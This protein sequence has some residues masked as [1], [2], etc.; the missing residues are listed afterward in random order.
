MSIV[1]AQSVRLRLPTSGRG[2]VKV[3]E[4]SADRVAVSTIV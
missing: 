3:H 4:A 2:R 1:P